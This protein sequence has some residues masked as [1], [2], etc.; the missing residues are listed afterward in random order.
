MASPVEL[1]LL[2]V[3][4]C[5]AWADGKVNTEEMNFIKQFIRKFQLTGDEW[6]EVEM[7]LVEKVPLEEMKGVTQRFLSKARRKKDRESLVKAVRGLLESSEGL[8]PQEKDWLS[9]LEEVVA[10]SGRGVF[11]LDGL[12]SLIRVGTR[13]AHTRDISREDD[14][15]DFIHNRALFKLRR[16]LG[17]RMLEK[18]GTPDKLK[19]LTL[20]ATFLG[21]VGYVDNDFLPQEE[22]YMKKVLQE[23][24]GTSAEA[25]GGV[26]EVALETV[27][28]GVD[29]HRLVQEAKRIMSVPERKRLVEG[30]FALSK[31]EGKT[32][33]DEIEEIRKIAY[34]LDFSHKLFIDTKLKVLGQ[35]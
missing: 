24:W 34:M 30:I 8:M 28:G 15:Y 3:L 31:A 35:S 32:S 18:E 33:N 14:L 10:E 25:V 12:K 2:K 26:I 27:R 22:A 9:A 6:A 1:E 20:S 11:L 17:S 21:C 16:R 19:K 13:S 7:Y 4:A 23:V 29:L 5:V